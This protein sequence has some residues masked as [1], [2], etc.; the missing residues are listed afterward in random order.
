VPTEDERDPLTRPDD[1]RSEVIRALA[2]ETLPQEVRPEPSKRLLGVD[3]EPPTLPPLLEL[4]LGQVEVSATDLWVRT[5]SAEIDLRWMTRDIDRLA[6]E[7]KEEIAALEARVAASD[8]KRWSEGRIIGSLAVL[9]G[10]AAGLAKLI[11]LG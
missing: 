3:L 5:L 7:H 10:L 2:A 9:V 1:I 6:R 8:G 11:G 4:G